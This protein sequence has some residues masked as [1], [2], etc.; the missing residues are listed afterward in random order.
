M[1][2]VVLVH[3]F[4]PQRIVI[5]GG[6]SKIGAP[7]LDP[8]EAYMRRHAFPT[9]AAAVR[10]LPARHADEAGVLGAAAVAFHGAGIRITL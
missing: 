4:N 5:G 6:A 7:L 3:L 8:A 1:G 2:L 10:V 9:L